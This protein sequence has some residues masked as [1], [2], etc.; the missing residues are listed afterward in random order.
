MAKRMLRSMKEAVRSKKGVNLRGASQIMLT[1][2]ETDE[3]KFKLVKDIA[4]YLKK[5]YDIKRVMRFAFIPADEKAI[6]TWHMRKL[7]SD[8]FCQSDLNWWERPVKNVQSHMDEPYD[9][10]IH[11]DPDEAMP[12]DFFVAG[13]KAKMKVANFSNSR[14]GDFDILIPAQPKDS[15]K[16]RNHRIIEFI[17]DS[18]LT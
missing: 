11:L 1:Y 6:P 13:S 12:L 8:F 2:T 7:E 3:R 4:L 5:E 10:L 9:I 15:W 16:Q 18:P 14:A 17:G